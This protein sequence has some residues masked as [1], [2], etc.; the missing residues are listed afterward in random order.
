MARQRNTATGV[1]VNVAD[2]RVL[3][4]YVVIVDEKQSKS[5]NSASGKSSTKK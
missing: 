2:G 1:V 3:D 4:G 5:T